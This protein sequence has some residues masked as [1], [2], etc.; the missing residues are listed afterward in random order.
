MI[1]YKALRQ[2]SRERRRAKKR[3]EVELALGP[4]R[5]Q[6]ITALSTC[7]DEIPVLIVCYNNHVYVENFIA[8]LKNFDI[9]PIV[10]DNASTSSDT[11]R[12]LSEKKLGNEVLVCNSSCNFGHLVGFHPAIYEVLPEHFCYSDPDLGF[13]PDLPKTFLEELKHIAL[14]FGSFK[15]GLALDLCEGEDIVPTKIENPLGDPFNCVLEHGIREFEARWWR[16]RLSYKDYEVWAAEVDTTLAVY[17]KSNFY[18]HFLDG[19]RVGGNFSAVHLP[20]FPKRDLF[21][22]RQREEYLDGNET[23]TTWGSRK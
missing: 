21:N 18:G 16:Y 7:T 5:R 20:W 15:A 4:L 2:R 1:S 3:A 23:S 14:H 11:K 12:Y 13:H 6:L 8:Q 22:D 19:V 10:I 9:T 17:C